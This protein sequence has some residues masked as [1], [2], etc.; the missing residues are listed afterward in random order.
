[1]K[2][3]GVVG[4]AIGGIAPLDPPPGSK[5]QIRHKNFQNSLLV[6][7]RLLRGPKLSKS[8]QNL[9]GDRTNPRECKAQKPL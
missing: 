4:N 7:Y 9:E 6:P 1:M 8:R 3:N 2:I 5:S